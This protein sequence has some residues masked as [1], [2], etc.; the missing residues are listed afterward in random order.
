MLRLETTTS[1]GKVFLGPFVYDL[2]ERQAKRKLGKM[3]W[4]IPKDSKGEPVGDAKIEFIETE[5][6]PREAIHNWRMEDL[7]VESELTLLIRRVERKW[8]KVEDVCEFYPTDGEPVCDCNS[9]ISGKFICNKE[10]SNTCQWANERRKLDADYRED[11]EE[12]E[13]GGA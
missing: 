2:D 5:V 10:Y 13:E 7:D 4:L 8:K 1:A 3:N 9:D 11:T 12:M 6:F